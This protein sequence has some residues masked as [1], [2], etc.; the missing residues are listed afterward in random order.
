MA[1]L[2]S[3]I[4]TL[5]SGYLLRI[6]GGKELYFSSNGFQPAAKLLFCTFQLSSPVLGQLMYCNFL[7]TCV[8]VSMYMIYIMYIIIYIHM[9][10]VRVALCGNIHFVYI[11]YI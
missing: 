8:N 4:Y 2:I 11:K 9:I 10:C 1:P 7:C 5:P 6:L 3:P